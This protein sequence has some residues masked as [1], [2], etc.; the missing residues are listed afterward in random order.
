M[1]QSQL[2]PDALWL[3]VQSFYHM[4]VMDIILMAAQVVSAADTACLQLSNEAICLNASGN[5]THHSEV[6][7]CRPQM[8]EGVSKDK[9]ACLGKSGCNQRANSH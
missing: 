3:S 1:L 2:G 4:H 6:C 8:H 5:T 9:P 7:H